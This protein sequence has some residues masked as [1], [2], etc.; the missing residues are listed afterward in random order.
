MKNFKSD[1]L[2]DA[3]YKSLNDALLSAVYNGYAEK[4]VHLLS[5]GANINCTSNH[6][7]YEMINDGMTPFMV[8]VERGNLPLIHKMVHDGFSYRAWVKGH[9]HDATVKPDIHYMADEK[10]DFHRGELMT[11][12]FNA[13]SIALMALTDADSAADQDFFYRYYEIAKTLIEQG[14]DVNAQNKSGNTALFFIGH[15]IEVDYTLLAKLLVDSGADVNRKNIYGDTPFSMLFDDEYVVN[16]TGKNDLVEYFMSL[17]DLDRE[18]N[19]VQMS[20]SVNVESDE[21]KLLIDAG[22]D[23]SYYQKAFAASLECRRPKDIFLEY[24]VDP[25]TRNSKGRTLLMVCSAVNYALTKGYLVG[26]DVNLRDNEGWSALTHA[27][28]KGNFKAV[29]ALI[30]R[31]ADVNVID[32]KGL[33]LFQH[34]RETGNSNMISFFEQLAEQAMLDGTIHSDNEEER[35][36]F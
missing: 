15:R 1:A 31:G 25:N 8:A 33:S 28:D 14:I 3:N 16:H 9:P 12:G 10:I 34:A 13:L 18:Y 21:L 27:V 6:H 20:K 36:S 29:V 17:P 35:I 23:K 26:V 5:K 11:K 30:E 22:V 2:K 32:N 19:L 7:P 24:G 4:I